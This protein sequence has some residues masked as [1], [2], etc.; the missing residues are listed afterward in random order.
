MSK[1]FQM[2]L[3]AVL[4][5]ALVA[6]SGAAFAVEGDAD[7]WEP[8][9]RQAAPA[10]PGGEE[11]PSP[12]EIGQMMQAMMIPMMGQMMEVMIRGMANALAQQEVADDFASFSRNLYT[13]LIERGFSEEEA[14]QIVTSSG[15]PSAGGGQR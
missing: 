4:A 3:A 12:E 8:G 2:M 14:M 15:F 1:R 7:Q 6:S 13:A 11:E 9:S 10:R 5:A